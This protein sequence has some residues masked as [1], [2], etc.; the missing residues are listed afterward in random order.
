M[1]DRL[2]VRLGADVSRR[3]L[4]GGGLGALLFIRV[5]AA[6]AK[7]YLTTR[8]HAPALEARFWAWWNRAALYAQDLKVSAHPNVVRFR[9]KL[10]A[11]PGDLGSLEL[12]RAVSRLVNAS[13]PYVADY[14]S[15]RGRDQWAS[16]IEFLERGGDCE[17]F[18]LT[19]AATMY[20]LGWPVDR[21]YLL[22]GLLDRPRIGPSG[23][24]VLVA[25][26]GD[27]DEREFVLDNTSDR[28]VSL[29]R[30]AAFT[31]IYGLDRR[32]VIMFT[33]SLD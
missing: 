12:I 2:R 32:G 10:A 7:S 16:P 31:P 13:A 29:D 33:K 30:F 1:A 22:V 20:R 17:D 15:S 14:R 26:P 5:R 9:R 3:A 28:V 24:A 23:H 19:K 8:V 27:G 18:A 4:L 25:V 11:L 6:H 21:T